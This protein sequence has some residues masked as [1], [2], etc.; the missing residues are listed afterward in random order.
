MKTASLAPRGLSATAEQTPGTDLSSSRSDQSQYENNFWRTRLCAGLSAVLAVL[1][2]GGLTACSSDSKPAEE[3]KPEV[4]G[5]ELITARSAFQKLYVAA[6][7]W[8]QDAKPYRI[9]STATT[10]GNGQDGKWAIWR[11]SFASAAQRSEKTYTWSGSAANGAPERGVNPGIEDSYSPSNAST[12]VFDMA[13]LKIDSDA[14]FAT[15][16]KHGGD[17]VL[18]KAPD[19]PVIYV[20]DWN[21]NTNELTWHV[22]YGASREGAKLTVAVNA[23]TGEFIRVEK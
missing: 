12:Q 4:K 19:T 11:C 5:P 21:H 9:E 7:G 13:F 17:K 22:I 3:A 20:C 18:E 15:A 1:L 23:S 14:A 16:Q 2:L 10:D 6:R 8:N